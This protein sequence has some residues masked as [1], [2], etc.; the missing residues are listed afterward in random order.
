MKHI[1]WESVM[2]QIDDRYILEAMESCELPGSAAASRRKKENLLMQNNKRRTI[3]RIG[4]LAAA[5]ALI[6]TLGMTAYANG[7]FDSII[8]KMSGAYATPDET[9][10]ARYEAAAENS[11]KE[12]ETAELR[13]LIGN[14]MTV[15][16]SFYDG[17]SLML[18]YSLDTM[19]YPIDYSFDA[20]DVRYSKLQKLES[21]SMEWFR[22]EF[23]ISDADYE[24]ICAKIREQ[25]DVSFVLTRVELGDHVA[26][27]DGTDIGPMTSMEIDGSVFLEPQNGLPEKARSRDQL[28]LVFT[29][30]CREICFRIDG[31]DIYTHWPEPRSEEVTFTIPRTDK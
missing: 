16:E 21:V 5:L 6:F 29:V 27:T 31:E 24:A 12:P 26:L 10:D 23:D 22:T 3:T 28:E 30:N 20:G 2:G 14:A 9:R 18:A 4:S 19:S 13:Q 25:G 1:R 7:F 15:E 8:A 17:D 11:D